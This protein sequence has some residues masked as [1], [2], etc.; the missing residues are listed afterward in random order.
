M[1]DIAVQL[2]RKITGTSLTRARIP[3]YIMLEASPRAL[4]DSDRTLS[5]FLNWHRISEATRLRRT[6]TQTT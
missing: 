1:L 6:D 3:A 2:R 5:L 4:R